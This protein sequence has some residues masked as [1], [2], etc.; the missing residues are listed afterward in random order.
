MS[1]TTDMTTIAVKNWERFQHYKD[2]DPPWIKLYR[3]MLTSEPWVLGTD[4]SRL[5]QV[6]I[7]LL[8]ARY[9]NAIPYQFQLLRKV[10]S[11]DCTEKQFGKAIDFLASVSFLEI[12]GVTNGSGLLAHGASSVLATCN[13]ETEGEQRERQSRAETE[14]IPSARKSA[15]AEAVEFLDFKIFYPNRAGDQGWRKALRSACA[16][17][18]EGHTWIEILDGAKRYAAFI[19]AGGKEGTEYV[20]QAATFL[21][22]DLFFLQPWTLPKSK[23]ENLRDQNIETSQDWL[24]ASNG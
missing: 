2:R 4:I 19:R 21:G 10:A 14:Q 24:H 23:A 7:T 5:V 13:T 8:A 9:S 11:L 6:A 20:K 12:Q 17:I 1:D 22:P 16:R 15:P 3:D 18:G